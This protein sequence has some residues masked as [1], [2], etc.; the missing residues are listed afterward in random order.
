MQGTNWTS[1][2]RHGPAR[3]T[4]SVPLRTLTQR[5]RQSLLLRLTWCRHRRRCRGKQGVNRRHR[6]TLRDPPQSFLLL[7]LLSSCRLGAINKKTLNILRYYIYSQ[8]SL[9][10][11]IIL[12]GHRRR[13]WDPPT[14]RWLGDNV[15]KSRLPQTLNVCQA[16]PKNTKPSKESTS[17]PALQEGTSKSPD[18]KLLWAELRIGGLDKGDTQYCEYKRTQTFIGG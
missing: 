6:H 3:P 10:P 14:R 8:R 9:S 13:P 1:P 17:S 5:C 18:F 16:Q 2:S 12:Q 7:L 11:I 15:D 4:W